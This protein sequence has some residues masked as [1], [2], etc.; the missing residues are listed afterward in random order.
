MGLEKKEE[1]VLPPIRTPKTATKG[2]KK[3]EKK[4]SKL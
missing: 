2:K 4:D 3:P 1:D